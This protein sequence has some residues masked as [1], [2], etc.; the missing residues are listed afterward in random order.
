[1]N[2]N[3]GDGKGG[4]VYVN[5]GSLELNDGVEISGNRSGNEYGGGGGMYV[6]N[7]GSIVM[8]GG[9]ISEN[10]CSAV[11]AWY[12]HGG[13]I[14]IRGNS[15]VTMSGGIIA[16]NTA[17]IYR[18]R[19]GGVFVDNGSSFIKRAQGG[20]SSGIIYGET[21][22]NANVASSLEGG[23]AI[24]RNFGTKKERNTTL[25]GYDEISTGNDVGWE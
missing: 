13:G 5:G 8:R 24:Y 12:H 18:S 9:L 2:T 21:G 23:H 7:L 4:G 16:K 15:T 6:E 1:M 11:G 3:I 20:G 22:D 19:G 10:T 25:G 17:S 14:Y